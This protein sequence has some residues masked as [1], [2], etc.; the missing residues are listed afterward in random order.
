M[1]TIQI[2]V[3]DEVNSLNAAHLIPALSKELHAEGVSIYDHAPL[4]LKIKSTVDNDHDKVLIQ[5]RESDSKQ[6]LNEKV[7]PLLRNSYLNDIA[8]EAHSLLMTSSVPA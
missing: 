3:V 4:T 8:K 1:H 6:K 7:I 5:L 2:K